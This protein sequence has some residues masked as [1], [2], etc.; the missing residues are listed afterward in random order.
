MKVKIDVMKCIA[1]GGCRRT[2]PAVFGQDE[3][4]MV[5]LLDAEPPPE[6]HEA[7]RAAAAGCPAAVI[8]IEDDA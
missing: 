5:S 1:S 7:A 4:G 8:T 6:L 2:A 3:D